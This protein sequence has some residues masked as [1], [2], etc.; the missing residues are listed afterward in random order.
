MH[1][2]VD[3]QPDKKPLKNGVKDS[4]ALLMKLK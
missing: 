3:S 2:L 1:S 4:V